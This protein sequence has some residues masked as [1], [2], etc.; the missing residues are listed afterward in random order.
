V[1]YKPLACIDITIWTQY[2]STH[3]NEIISTSTESSLSII[4]TGCRVT[5]TT[6]A[7]IL[8]F[9]YGFINKGIVFWLNS[10]YTSIIMEYLDAY[11]FEHE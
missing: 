7:D 11:L 9:I 4:K 3:A 2:F 6:N 10:G 5:C 8:V 1:G